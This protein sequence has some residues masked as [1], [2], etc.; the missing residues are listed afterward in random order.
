[1]ARQSMSDLVDKVSTNGRSSKAKEY[2]S[3]SEWPPCTV[4]GCPLPTTI[5]D[6]RCTC[7]YH[8]RE[9]GFMADCITEAIN[10]NL[11]FIKKYNSMLFWNVREWK[12]KAPRIMGWPVLPATQ[13]EIDLPTRYLWRLKDFIDKNIKERSSEIYQGHK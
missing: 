1:M 11:S 12:E 4:A 2:A 7:G 3:A 13:E 8:H 9:N 10:E 6:D 5:K